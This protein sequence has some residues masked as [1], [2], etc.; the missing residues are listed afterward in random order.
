[1]TINLETM[2]VDNWLYNETME[3]CYKTSDECFFL[4]ED[5][6]GRRYPYRGYVPDFFPNKHYGDYIQL[7]INKDGIVQGLNCS[8]EE[9]EETLERS[10]DFF[11]S[12]MQF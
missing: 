2:V 9:I 8:D 6:K 1:M 11:G 12:V 4:F 7:V 10:Y 5:K 3:T